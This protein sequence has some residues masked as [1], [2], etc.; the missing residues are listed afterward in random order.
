MRH[1]SFPE[2]PDDTRQHRD[3]AAVSAALCGLRVALR[4]R[5]RRG[6]VLNVHGSY[7]FTPPNLAGRLRPLRDPATPADDELE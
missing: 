1:P 2:I 5:P 7:A 4:P 6:L 3:G